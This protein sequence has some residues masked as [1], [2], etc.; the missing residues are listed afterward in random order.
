MST[1]IVHSFQLDL[2]IFFPKQYVITI[3]KKLQHNPKTT[4]K[5]YEIPKK[6]ER[7]KNTKENKNPEQ[8]FGEKLPLPLEK[9]F[10]FSNCF[11]VFR[12]QFILAF[13]RL[14]SYF[15]LDFWQNC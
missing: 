13:R 8:T 4:Q 14:I 15:A 1:V 12:N 6:I 11:S 5:E 10:K 7:T 3:L 9:P 2:F